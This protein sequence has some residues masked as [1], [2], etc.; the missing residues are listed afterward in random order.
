MVQFTPFCWLNLIY[1]EHL[2][3]QKERKINSAAL[4]MN[5]HEGLFLTNLTGIEYLRVNIIF[6]CEDLKSQNSA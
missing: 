3:K 1:Q 5:T 2:K 4:V 6:S